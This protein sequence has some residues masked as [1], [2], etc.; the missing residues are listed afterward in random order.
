MIRAI[1]FTWHKVLVLGATM[2]GFAVGVLVGVAG[3]AALEW[4]LRTDERKEAW[5]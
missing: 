1:V 2:L 3:V 4:I 5:D